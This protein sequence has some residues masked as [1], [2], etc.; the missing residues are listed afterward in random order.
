MKLDIYHVG[1]EPTDAYY[2]LDDMIPQSNRYL[3]GKL[4]GKHAPHLKEFFFVLHENGKAFSR[5]WMGMPL[6]ENAVANWGDVYTREECQ[7]LG[8]CSKTLAF[9]MDHIKKM[10]NPPMGLFCTC[11]RPWIANMYK[12]H[13]FVPALRGAENGPLYCPLGDSPKTFQDLCDYYYAPTKSLRTCKATWEWRN[14]IDCLLNFV[15]QD[16]G[17]NYE[18]NGSGSLADLLTAES[19]RDIRVILTEEDR[20]VGWMIDGVAQIHPNYQSM[21]D[22]IR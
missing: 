12:K 4:E 10:P 1:S 15:F 9:C 5:I 19:Q 14:E 6:H 3:R 20:C 16:M 17:E 7:G 13:G 8:Y 22:T 18:I 11:G 2:A 21:L